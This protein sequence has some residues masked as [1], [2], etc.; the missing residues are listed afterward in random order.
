MVTIKPP[1]VK[2]IPLQ[3][4]THLIVLM[5]GMLI[6]LIGFMLILGRFLPHNEIAFISE[7]TGNA[8]VFTMDVNRNIVYNLTHDPAWERGLIWSPD[9]ERLAFYSNRTT[10]W[11]VYTLDATGRNLRQVTDNRLFETNL[12]WFTDSDSL[13][14]VVPG[15]TERTLVTIDTEGGTFNQ[16]AY[17]DILSPVW[18]PDG[19]RIAYFSFTSRRF[20]L[21]VMDAEGENRQMITDNIRPQPRDIAWSADQEQI[22]FVAHSEIFVSNITTGETRQ[23]T[24]MGQGGAWEPSWSPDGLYI[25][26][27]S[28]HEGN[29]E[30]YL[31]NVAGDQL[32]RLTHNP[33]NDGVP[34]WQ[35]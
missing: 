35:P 29:A 23:L 8:D 32:R 9:G 10:Q 15:A 2:I 14:F 18:S 5:T 28:F 33:A 13:A 30:L 20:G 3:A 31:L 1:L 19:Q 34:V 24:F 27:M 17:S 7:R 16:K 12:V 21:F 25:A 4:A 22:A 6:I 11:E 26:F